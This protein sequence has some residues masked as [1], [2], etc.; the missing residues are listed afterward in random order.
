MFSQS[1]L[2][3]NIFSILTLLALFSSFGCSK[4]ADDVSAASATYYESEQLFREA[5]PFFAESW[6]SSAEEQPSPTGYGGSVPFQRWDLVPEIKTNFKGIAFS[7][8]YKEDR[9]HVWA[10][11][12]LFETERTGANSPGACLTCKTTAVGDIFEA[13]GWDFASMNLNELAESVNGG[14]DCFTCHDPEGGS[15]RVIQ[16]AFIDSMDQMGLEWD[17]LSHKDQS[18]YTCAQCHSEYYFAKDENGISAVV[19][20]WGMGL[21]PEEQY[22]YYQS[23]SDSYSGDYTQP[24]SGVRLIKVQHPDYEEYREG[25]H[26]AAGVTCADCHMPLIDSEEGQIKSHKIT[27]PLQSVDA[28]CLPCH[29]GKTEEWMISRVKAIQDSV[30]DS[31]RRSGKTIERAHQRIAAAVDAGASDEELAKARELLQEGQWYWDF[32]ASANSH[33]FHNSNQAHD[34]FSRASDLAGRA[35]EAVFEI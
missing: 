31:M 25:I 19:H 7:K 11:D 8:D 30:Y 28:S 5:H 9:G 33:G 13:Y 27:S 2:I 22:A 26:A 10:W 6:D 20:P 3:K 35:I 12:D 21:K 16:P 23:I 34:N 17:N 15:L 24:D 29:Q 18:I 1:I 14:I 32:S 4:K